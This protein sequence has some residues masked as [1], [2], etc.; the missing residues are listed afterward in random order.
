MTDNN[1][2]QKRI[3]SYEK[4]HSIDEK[5]FDSL[6][7][8]VDPKNGES[9]LD[10]CCG[11]GSVSKRILKEIDKKGLDLKITLLDN[12]ELQLE[13]AKE[14]L[15]NNVNIKFV[16]SDAIET[17]FPEN[18]FD[19]VV[20]K[21][22]LHEVDKESQYKMLKESYRII[23]PGGKIVI[24]ELALDDKTQPIF[25]EIIKK[26][27][28]IAGFDSLVR[29]R[30]FPKKDDV[31]VGLKE[32]GFKYPKVEHDVFPSLSIRNRKEELISVDRLT[33]LDEKGFIDESEE[34]N[35]QKTAEDK[36]EELRRYIR[37]KLSEEEKILMSFSE[38]ED[39]TILK[40]PKAIFKALKL[41]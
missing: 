21:M 40:A 5:D 6:I 34:F 7:A 29:N 13:R 1:S 14:N 41:L 11:Y 17:P 23:K 8:I 37:E 12:S 16:L 31:L 32:A 33:M 36:V 38:S 2:Y 28:Q 35:L 26:K 27:D 4:I 39:D 24:W 3:V 9:I 20:N 25:S 10:V 15:K 19:T 22:G 30:Y 18:H